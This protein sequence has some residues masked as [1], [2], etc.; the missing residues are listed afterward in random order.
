MKKSITQ[1]FNY[2]CGI[3]CF[4]FV[5]NVTYKKAINFLGPK[6]AMSP[7]F[8]CKNLASQLNKF[9]VKY[10]YRYVKPKLRKKIYQEGAI[11]L[12]ARSKIYPTGHYLIRYK[13]QWMDLWINLPKD[14]NIKHAKS[15]FRKR[16]PCRPM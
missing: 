8:W 14:E 5:T 3:A 7:R 4:A 15:G 9:G 6:Q 12:V 13:S 1:E 10:I 16:L 11:V 2:G